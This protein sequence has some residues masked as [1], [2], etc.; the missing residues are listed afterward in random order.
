MRRG[1]S[2]SGAGTAG[3]GTE[4]G[5]SGNNSS[6]GN[7]GT[8]TGDAGTSTA[9]SPAISPPAS[10]STATLEEVQPYVGGPLSELIKD[11]GYPQRSEYEDVDEDDPDTD[12]IGTLYFSGFVVTTLRDKNG[13][14]IIGVQAEDPSMKDRFDP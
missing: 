13:E 10:A 9:T 12:R 11:L 7:S 3:N 6:G 1:T 2:G 4:P 14:T 8:G 5:G